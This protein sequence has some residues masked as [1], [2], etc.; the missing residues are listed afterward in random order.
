MCRGGQCGF[1]VSKY[2]SPT[3]HDK[4]V[5]FS[6]NAPKCEE[7]YQHRKSYYCGRVGYRCEENICLIVTVKTDNKLVSIETG[8]SVDSPS[9]NDKGYGPPPRRWRGK[10]VTGAN[11]TGCN[12]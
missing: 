3:T 6:R 5:G 12:K 10:C 9:F 2:N 4:V 7:K 11:F 1:C 8:I